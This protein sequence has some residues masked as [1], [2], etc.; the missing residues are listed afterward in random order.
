MSALFMQAVP[1]FASLLA[2]IAYQDKPDEAQPR[3]NS[4]DGASYRRFQVPSRAGLWREWEP[5]V[6]RTLKCTVNKVSSLYL[7]D[8]LFQNC[9]ILFISHP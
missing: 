3:P 5:S 1:A 4:E 6:V 7:R 2:G 9:S 8:L